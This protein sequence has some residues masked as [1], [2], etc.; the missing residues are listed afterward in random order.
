MWGWALSAGLAG[1][2]D[3]MAFGGESRRHLHFPG[4]QLIAKGLLF[5]PLK[6]RG[7]WGGVLVGRCGLI[8]ARSSSM[9]A[10]NSLSVGSAELRL[11][12]LGIGEVIFL[13]VGV[14]AA[15]G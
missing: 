9:H 12:G 3:L 6:F 1:Q 5:I 11:R 2:R 10:S 15:G 4:S 13:D 7:W 8:P 14:G